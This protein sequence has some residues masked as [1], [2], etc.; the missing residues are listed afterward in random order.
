MWLNLLQESGLVLLVESHKR[1][2]ISASE[3]CLHLTDVAGI[4]N[5][6]TQ[7]N[8]LKHVVLEEVSVLLQP[9]D[10][11]VGVSVELLQ[12]SESLVPHILHLV[13]LLLTTYTCVR[14][15]KHKHL[16]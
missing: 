12:Q 11:V 7:Q 9:D 6:H 15:L 8:G 2:E 3:N 1:V 13:Q 16:G 5:I 10:G 14:M 4:T